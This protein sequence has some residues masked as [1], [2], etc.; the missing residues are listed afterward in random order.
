MYF[1]G[2][3]PAKSPVT[4]GR[5]RDGREEREGERKKKKEKIHAP[6]SYRER[7]LLG[8]PKTLPKYQANIN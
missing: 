5:E 6:K 2:R 4:V 1:G 3:S 8:V 7:K